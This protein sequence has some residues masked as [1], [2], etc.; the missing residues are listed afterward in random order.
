[1][2]AVVM[3]AIDTTICVSLSL[4]NYREETLMP[5]T[6]RFHLGDVLSITTGRL[7]SPDQIGGIYNIL[8]WMSGKDLHT[9]QLPRVGEEATP[10]L[11]AAF[12]E[13]ADIEVPEDINAET[14]DAWLKSLEPKYGTYRDV[15]RMPEGEHFRIDPLLELQH[16]VGAD[17]VIVV[18]KE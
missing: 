12:P 5:D 11:L 2:S 8:G 9:H 15:P 13:L 3:Y 7:V 14:L 6:K 18:G 1:M 4:G 10:T 16:K 17:N